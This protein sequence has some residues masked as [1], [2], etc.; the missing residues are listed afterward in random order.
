MEQLDCLHKPWNNSPIL[1]LVRR[2]DIR[3]ILSAYWVIILNLKLNLN[4][5]NLSSLDFIY[6]VVLVCLTFFFAVQWVPCIIMKLWLRL[7]QTARHFD[8]CVLCHRC[9]SVQQCTSAPGMEGS[10]PYPFPTHWS[11]TFSLRAVSSFPPLWLNCCDEMIF[12]GCSVSLPP[13]FW[14]V[15]WLPCGR[16]CCASVF[17]IVNGTILWG[18]WWRERI[19]WQKN[20]HF[21]NPASHVRG[22]SV[23]FSLSA[24]VSFISMSSYWSE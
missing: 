20:D 15:L 14:N 2:R 18:W 4:K 22:C 11:K 21:L 1:R 13:Y 17:Q 16:Y 12:D 9:L 7:I 24:Q 10:F 5:R 23:F 19:W 6:F 8:N 3:S